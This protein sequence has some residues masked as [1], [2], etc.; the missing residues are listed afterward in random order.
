V[1]LATDGDR[2]HQR[3]LYRHLKRLPGVQAVNER[4]DSIDNLVGTIIKTQRIFIG[5]LIFF[6]G[7][8][9][10]GSILNSSLIG[11]AERQRE[12]ATL[13]VL[14]YAPRQIGGLFLRESLVINTAGT[15][16][17]LPLGYVLTQAMTAAYETEL[18]RIPVVSEPWV[19]GTTLVL[20]VVFGL[21]A[22]QLVQRAID[23]LE[24]REALNVKE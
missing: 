7:V 17:G 2:N 8:I 12:V 21:V 23:R 1:Q 6:A 22:H 14:G 19:G 20:S 13:R 24:W 9:F 5:L 16:L 11:L 15:L 18:F 4:A 10:F 3:A